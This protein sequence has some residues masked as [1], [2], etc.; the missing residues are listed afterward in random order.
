MA[1]E[2]LSDAEIE[3]LLGKRRSTSQGTAAP[4]QQSPGSQPGLPPRLAEPLLRIHQRCAR[5]FAVELSALL[6]RTVRVRVVEIRETS[7]RESGPRHDPG[8]GTWSFDTKPHLG[9]WQAEI[10][11]D[12]LLPMID[13]MLGGGREPSAP[14]RRPLT[15]I[16][17]RLG[18]RIVRMFL[19]A[20]R[21][22]WQEVTTLPLEMAP[23]GAAVTNAPATAA[24]GVGFELEMAAAR[25][26]MQL[27]IP[28]P[29]VALLLGQRNTCLP[30][31]STGTTTNSGTIE[32]VASLGETHIEPEELA[33][34]AVGDIIATEQVSAGPIAVSHEGVIK[35]EARLG[36]SQGRKALEIERAVPPPRPSGE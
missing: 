15:E 2:L 31:D 9:R 7:P 3:V 23:S 4:A 12:I 17:T 35:F 29:T 11:S 5:E 24:I 28:L 6:R 27:S 36:A 19:A 20:L 14:I 1:D 8:G 30:A 13:C 16:E 18:E 32:L 26:T 10:A 33:Q 21:S 34:L 25:G 22:S